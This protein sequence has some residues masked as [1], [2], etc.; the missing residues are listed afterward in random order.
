MR[1]ADNN[2]SIAIN[3]YLLPN[4]MRILTLRIHPVK[5]LPSA[6]MAVGGLLAAVAV[7]S[8]ST[9]AR[10]ESAAVW[11]LTAFLI[12]RF[13][14][15]SANWTVQFVSLT[16]RRMLLTSGVFSHEVISIALPKLADMT[17]SR[18]STGRLLGYGAFSIEVNGKTRTVLD[19]IP[20]PEQVYLE[21]LN[22]LE[23][24]GEEEDQARKDSLDQGHPTSDDL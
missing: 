21:V 4:E 18:S 11:T 1:L 15:V 17:F 9:G 20:Y 22:M 23:G 7:S 3:R 2:P 8:I 10:A 6:T 14:L 19:Y 16:D 12:L 13:F 5:I 24:S